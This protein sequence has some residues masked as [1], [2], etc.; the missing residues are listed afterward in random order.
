MLIVP[1]GFIYVQLSGQKDPKSLWPNT[2][3]NN[4]SPNYAGLFFRAEGGGANNFGTIQEEQTQTIFVKSDF[5]PP[6]WD[7]GV[8]HTVTSTYNARP[9]K[10]GWSE[11][12][13]DQYSLN[14]RHS[15]DEIRPRNQ[16]IR[17]WI[18]IK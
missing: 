9:F 6:V 16:A 2:D 4:V 5:K 7:L 18:R 3:W 11:R 8:E 17:I 15:T 1:I 12:P 14:F 10:T 13:D